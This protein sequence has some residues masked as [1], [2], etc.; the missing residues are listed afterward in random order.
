MY[1]FQYQLS[2]LVKVMKT[3]FTISKLFLFLQIV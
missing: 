2:E 3:M 1:T